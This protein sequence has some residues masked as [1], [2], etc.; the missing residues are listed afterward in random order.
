MKLDETAEDHLDDEETNEAW[1]CVKIMRGANDNGTD[2]ES[3]NN[4]SLA[5]N[6]L[7]DDASQQTSRIL[8][9]MKIRR[10]IK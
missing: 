7:E 9:R 4:I 2:T 3:L 1:K 10:V 5:N 6:K 8:V